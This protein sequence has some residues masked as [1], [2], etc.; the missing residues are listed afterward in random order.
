[1]VMALWG[2]ECLNHGSMASKYWGMIEIAPQD[3]KIIGSWD[4]GSKPPTK[5]MGT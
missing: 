5:F 1:M 3:T 4:H 2:D